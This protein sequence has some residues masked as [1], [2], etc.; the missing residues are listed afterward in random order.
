MTETRRAGVDGPATEA[1]LKAGRFFT[2][3]DESDDGRAVFREGGRAG[4][5]FYRDR[6]SHDKVVRST[7]GVNCTGSC[8]WKVYVKDGIITWE[9]QQTDYPSVGPDRPEYEPRGCPRG[10]AFSWYTY[11]PTR[12]R[13]PYVRGVLLEMYREARAR[14][15]DPVLAWAE[16]TGDREKRRRYQHAR[17]KGGL[18][19][20]SWSEAVEIAAAAHVH[21]IKTYG[22]DRVAG[23]SPIP[24]MS[25][26]SH[27][28][29]TRFIQL[30]G[31]VMTSF[32]DWYA[33]LPV[34]SPQVFGDQTDVPES[35]DWWD[36]TYL[37]MWG[38][39]VPV[40]RTPDA[41][42]MAEVRY[43][44]TKVVTVSPDYADN[45]K[46]ADEWMAAQ[47]GTDAALAMAMGHVILTEHF[48]ERQTP[49]F[50]D[51]V[52]SYTDLPFL[53][54]LEPAAEGGDAYLPG[55]FLTAADLDPAAPD[56]DAWKT[57]V[58][59]ESSTEPVVP[60]G[61]MGF[62]YAESGKGRWNL[63]LDGVTPALSLA[64]EGSTA[65]EVLLPAFT[66]PDGSGSVLHRGV[67]ARRVGDRLVTTVLDLMLAQ[68]GVR[69]EGLP[70]AWPTGYD[71]AETPYTPAWQAEITGVP[72]EQCLRVAREFAANSEE[73]QGRSMII[74]GAGICQWFHGDAT[75]RSILSLLI[76]TGC[77]GR[78]G[79]GWAHYV[80]Q[81]KCRPITGWISLANALDWTRPP[82]TMIG[83]A[84]WY[85]HTDQWR[86]DG[87]SADS[88]SWPHAKG[89]LAGKHT[90]D[91]IAQ[92]ARLGW[93]P[94]YPQF[95]TN[96]LQVA[97]DADAAVEAG[98][99]SSPA[100]Y[101][102][103]S[104]HDGSLRTAIEDVDAPENWPRTLVLWRSN[105]MG[106]SAKGNEYFLK[107]LLGTHSNVMGTE[108][109]ETPRPS[110]VAWHDEAP[111]GKLDLLVSA[112]FRM[113]ST[114]LLSDVVLP[115]ATW[116]EK[117]DLSSTDMHPFVH[118]FTPAI[119]PPWEAKSDFDLFHLLA[120]Q[121]SA[122]ARTHLGVRKDLVSVPLM[123][124]TPGETAQPGGR[125]RDWRGTG[126]PGTP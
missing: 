104:L 109:P 95:A 74:M 17:G 13:Y 26:V 90:A 14:L 94:F 112:D 21:T 2:R 53:V 106:S 124:D 97:D 55:K 108:N 64:G 121:F 37:M 72:A 71:D 6:W 87:Y 120:Q 27:C 115:A 10:A 117:H 56:E 77:M 82:R 80:G 48:V 30:I 84:Y 100:A 52:R 116:Y 32:Y 89:H 22:P 101:V 105:L 60:N 69:R 122:M 3:W 42:W 66:E 63:D 125:V 47:A 110:E 40:T 102:A 23:F 15:G 88:L 91:T 93:M 11:S 44:G 92:S 83:T 70:G 25:M 73:S 111:E 79:G 58:L 62:R 34:A 103:S 38:S 39:N 81:E 12:V 59:D 61:S 35:G 19:R 99:A 126:L 75:Y 118:A 49:F 107:H 76:L 67:P 29:G 114:T 65:I 24:A 45:T 54:C 20:A 31:G 33:D 86:N 28:V 119:D 46:F 36:A 18:V 78:N 50:H 43:R 98:R 5:V 41:H 7:H 9:T 85:M 123:H 16:I 51:Y 96:P 8:S 113:T 1:L 4:D 68:Y 57:V